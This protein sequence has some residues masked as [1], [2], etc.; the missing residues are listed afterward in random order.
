MFYLIVR[1]SVEEMIAIDPRKAQQ[2]VDQRFLENLTYPMMPCSGLVRLNNGISMP[3]LGLGTWRAA[4][5]EV[6]TAV[7][8]AIRHGYRHLDLADRYLN[9]VAIGNALEDLRLNLKTRMPPIYVTTK[10]WNSDH[11]PERVRPAVLRML[12]E[13]KLDKLD[14]LLM[15]WP[16]AVNRTCSNNSSWHCDGQPENIPLVETWV[17]MEKLV[18]EGLVV[19]LG[20]SNFGIKRLRFFRK[21]IEQASTNVFPAVN[22]VE[23]HPYLPQVELLDF[24]QTMNISVVAYSPLGSPGNAAQ[25]APFGSPPPIFQN[26][27]IKQLANKRGLTS[28]QFVLAWLLMRGVAAVIPKS[29]SMR[30]IKE[31]GFLH[32]ISTSLHEKKEIGIPIFDKQHPVSCESIK[33]ST[34]EWMS[35]HD[36]LNMST[37]GEAIKYRYVDITT[38]QLKGVVR[39]PGENGTKEAFWE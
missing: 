38:K 16:I 9:H 8:F 13:L 37:I 22:Q 15:H 28:A 7:N 27:R 11:K 14:L 36:M 19:S 4:P 34:P 17:A 31:N 20:V 35:L 29:T 33:G 3:R 24:C 32:L 39:Y 5:S 21:A 18:D 30:H 10:L 6:E 23:I 25:K 26:R 1:L 2:T 12:R